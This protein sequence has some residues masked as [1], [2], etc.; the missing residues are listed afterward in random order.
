MLKLEG[1]FCMGECSWHI[2][3]LLLSLKYSLAP[4]S[5]DVEFLAQK[6]NF[7]VKGQT[8]MIAMVQ[9]R[10]DS[11]EEVQMLCKPIDH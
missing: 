11:L 2:L 10:K 3:S 4:Q 1:A 5:R 9:L 7:E 8:W 6:S